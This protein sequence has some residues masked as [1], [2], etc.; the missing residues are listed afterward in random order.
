MNN[1]NMK[2]FS[3]SISL[4]ACAILL[5]SGC[6]SP[7]TT[8]VDSDSSRLI[9]N[10]EEINIQ[11]F[12]RAA[13]EMVQ[14]IIENCIST[15]DLE[16][17]DGKKPILAISR[18][19]NNTSVQFDTDLLVKRIRTALTRTGKVQTSTTL[20]LSKSEDPLALEADAEEEILTNERMKHAYSLSGKIL[21][22]SAQSG[23]VRQNSYEFQLT[24]S[25]RRGLVVWEDI[26]T[27]TKQGKKPS[28]GF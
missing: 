12:S 11:D 22:V 26:K 5:T 28:V 4:I 25:N 13:D 3:T 27:I 23:R 8:Y 14:S 24:L 18:I 16:G 6:A 20:N 10:V 19:V 15:G 7:K 2:T 9:T 17:V 1:Q 21:E